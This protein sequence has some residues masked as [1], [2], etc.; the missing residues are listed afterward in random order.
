MDPDKS[1]VLLSGGM[2]STTVLYEA[3]NAEVGRNV[4]AALSFDYGQR[5]A[6]ELNYAFR[7]A[8]RLNV[9]HQVIS[10]RDVT[11]F[12]KGS[13]LTD[14]IEVPEGHYAEDNM[15]LTI[16]PN[17]NSMMLNIAAGVAIGLG[18][19]NVWA[20]MHAGDH[21]VYPDCRPE[22]I[23]SLNDTLRLA[24]E[25][26]VSIV[27]PYILVGKDK[28]VLRGSELGVPF[29]ETWS[30]YEG[31][32]IHCGRCGTCVERAEAFSLADVP[33]PTLY[34]DP[35]FWKQAVGIS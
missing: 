20:A 3:L 7:T 5:H 11:R 2:D 27:T 6:T 13:S 28:I 8:D 25:T 16:V 19:Q 10:L 23:H 26:D 35:D 12:L 22:F 1:V 4:V 32:N 9:D 17:R 21:P 31:G 30:C 15:R 14:D 34:T 33:D 24:T 18:A 29:E